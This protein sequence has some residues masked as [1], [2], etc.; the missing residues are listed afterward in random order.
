MFV[1]GFKAAGAGIEA[2][3]LD[4]KSS[5]KKNKNKNITQDLVKLNKLY[6]SKAI[7]KKNFK[8]QKKKY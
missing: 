1:I 7:S 2:K 8:K 5:K 3:Q 4:N 6:K